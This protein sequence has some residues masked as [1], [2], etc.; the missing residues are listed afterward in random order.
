MARKTYADVQEL[1]REYLGVGSS[2][3]ETAKVKSIV[4]TGY[5]EVLYPIDGRARGFYCWSFLSKH[6]TLTTERGTSTYD[7]P[8]DFGSL[9]YGFIW[10]QDEA[11]NPIT[12]VEYD[13]L[14]EAQSAGETG[15]WP[16]MF[17]LIP[18]DGSNGQSWQVVFYPTPDGEYTLYYG[19]VIQPSMPSDDEDTFAGPEWIDDLVEAAALAAA[20]RLMLDRLGLW[21]QYFRERLQWAIDKDRKNHSKTVDVM[22][23]G[24]T[25]RILWGRLMSQYPSIET[26]DE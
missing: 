25:G 5:K 21:N 20:E 15:S 10:G 22:R 23:L 13:Q 16:R 11:K 26:F 14:L 17:A 3:S 4:L 18:K 8:D 9:S 19:Y 24:M 6:T 12:Q 2:A 1:V 7:L